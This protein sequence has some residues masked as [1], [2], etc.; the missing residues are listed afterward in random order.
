MNDPKIK[1]QLG[2]LG[3]LVLPGS[4]TVFANLIGEETEK[5]GR[6]V[7]FSGAKPK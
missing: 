3:A 1:A 4:S 6:V 2:I 5:W 7:K